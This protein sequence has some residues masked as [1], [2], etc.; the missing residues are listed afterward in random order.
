MKKANKTKVLIIASLIPVLLGGLS[1]FLARDGFGIY[2]LLH[3]P[4]FSPPGWVF[5][6]VWMLL[7]LL[8]GLASGLVYSSEASPPRKK[9]ALRLY[10][11]QLVLNCLWPIVFFSWGMYLAV[12]FLLLVLWALVLVCMT[13]FGYISKTAGRLLLPYFLWLCFA[14]YLNLGVIIL[15]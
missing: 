9:K 15:N 11:V 14:A 10:G 1:G 3:K 6:V 5:P 4:L 12:F 13:L 2:K 8:M 7:Y